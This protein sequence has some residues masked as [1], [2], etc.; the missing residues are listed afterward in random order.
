VTLEKQSQTEER[1]MGALTIDIISDLVCPWCFIGSRRVELALEHAGETDA[2]IVFHPFLLDPSLPR[3]GVDLRER[4]ASKFGANPESMFGRV[5]Q[6]AKESGIPLDFAKV[7]RMPNTLKGHTLLRHLAESDDGAR[8][9]P[10]LARA[11]FSAYFLEG[12]DIGDDTVLVAIAKDHGLS[13]ESARALLADE[14]ELAK[15]LAEARSASQQGISGVPFT[16]VNQRLAV[17]GA[18]PVEVFAQAFAQAR[19]SG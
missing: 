13:E 8:T 9:Q 15:T 17:S 19:K 14:A 1:H 11:L 7:R 12:K 6:A 2:T 3:E 5:E 18:Q 10:K 16:I 4:L